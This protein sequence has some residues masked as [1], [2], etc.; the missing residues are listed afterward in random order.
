MPNRIEVVKFRGADLLTTEKDGKPFVALKPLVE[1]LG[2]NWSK[3]LQ[4]IKRDVVLSEGMSVMDIPSPGGAQETTCLPLGLLAGW[5]F[6]LSPSRYTGTMRENLIAFQREG[7]DVLHSYWFK[8]AAVNPRFAPLRPPGEISET[9][10]KPK[11]IPVRGH[12][13]SEPTKHPK[14]AE[15]DMSQ[16]VFLFTGPTTINMS[17]RQ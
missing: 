6:K 14:A 3:Q 15:P 11:D 4:L 8:G 1:A 17:A 10:G 5:L 13:R 7:Y 16:P 12:Y 9:T 2:L